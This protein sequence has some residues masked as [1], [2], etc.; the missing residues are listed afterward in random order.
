MERLALVA[1]VLLAGCATVRSIA[2]RTPAGEAVVALAAPSRNVAWAVGERR[3]D[4]WYARGAESIRDTRG[5][6][7]NA[8]NL[9]RDAVGTSGCCWGRV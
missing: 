7:R 3:S 5:A 4:R 6:R 2:Y 9:L 8:T 1:C